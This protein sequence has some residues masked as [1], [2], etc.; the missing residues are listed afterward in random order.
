MQA[1][2]GKVKYMILLPASAS[3]INLI[4]SESVGSWTWFHNEQLCLAMRPA[5]SGSRL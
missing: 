5:S 4:P 3:S 1:I 2:G